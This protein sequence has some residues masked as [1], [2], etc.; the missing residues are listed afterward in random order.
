MKHKLKIYSVRWRRREPRVLWYVSCQGCT[1]EPTNSFEWP[2]GKR[3]FGRPTLDDAVA[4]GALHQLR[5]LGPQ[6][7][8]KLGIC[9]PCDDYDELHGLD[10]RRE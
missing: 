10:F 4:I 5:H 6:E 3:L 9:P 8:G 7:R 1:W 2:D